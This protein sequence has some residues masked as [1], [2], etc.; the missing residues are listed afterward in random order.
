MEYSNFYD[1]AV[2]GNENWR[3]KFTEKEIACNA[4]DYLA[5]FQKSNETGKATVNMQELIN[6]LNEDAHSGSKRAAEF[7][8][9]ILE[10]AKFSYATEE[11]RKYRK[12]K[13]WNEMYDY[14][15]SGNDLYN[16]ETGDYVFE[17]N[18]AHALC[19]YHLGEDE[20]ER[21]AKAAYES[22][23]YWG[24]FLGVGGRVL[25]S[26]EYN[27]D[28]HRYSDDESMRMLYLQPSIN[29]C[30]EVFDKEGW[31]DTKDY[32]IGNER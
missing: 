23:E 30:K 27:D 4:Y 14:L 5:E 15:T 2:Y 6:T 8:E 10:N 13:S 32:K 19:I 9:I 26:Y 16:M 17:Y 25:D 12:F 11:V 3:G 24:S 31:V 29:Y 7:I 18:N 28:E 21:L 20:A 22:D 1:I